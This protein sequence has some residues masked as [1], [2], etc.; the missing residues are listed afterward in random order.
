MSTIAIGNRTDARPGRLSGVI[1]LGAALCVL[2]SIGYLSFCGQEPRETAVSP[3]NVAALMAAAVGCLVLSLALVRLQVALPRWTVLVAAAGIW[4]AGA[5]A[6]A[7][8]TMT[9]GVAGK[10]DNAEFE[11]LFLD[12]M[13]VL[14]SAMIPKSVLCAVGFLGIAIA[15]WRVRSVPRSAAILFGFAGVLSLWPPFPPGLILASVALVLLV[16]SRAQDAVT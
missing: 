4:F 16:R 6:W 1:T 14:G 13:W 10:L 5:Y 2:G 12:D 7:P 15:G 8:A 9:A 3:V 11:R